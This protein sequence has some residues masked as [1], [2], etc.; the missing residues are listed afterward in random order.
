MRQQDK[1]NGSWRSF[2]GYRN[3]GYL[4]GFLRLNPKT[5][6]TIY[7]QQT[8]NEGLSIPIHLR[9]GEMLPGRFEEGSPIK[10]YTRILGNYNLEANRLEVR[11]VALDFDAPGITE[12]PLESQWMTAMPDGLEPSAFL[13]TLFGKP[14]SITKVVS[15]DRANSVEIAGHV[16]GFMMERERY[17]ENG[18]MMARKL[19]MFVQQGADVMQAIPVR[20]KGRNVQSLREKI[21]IGTPVFVRAQLRMKHIPIPGAQPDERGLVPGYQ[22]MF[23]DGNAWGQIDPKAATRGEHVPD[24]PDWPQWAR[25]LAI[26]G[27]DAVRSAL[28]D[29]AERRKFSADDLASRE[30][31]VGSKHIEEDLDNLDTLLEQS[32]VS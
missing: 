32:G 20:Y 9:K 29:A 30:P 19:Y 28:R 24:L 3:A 4:S 23:I 14:E 17:L 11:A 1:Q 12:M 27:Q 7:L 22:M 26:K 2:R 8:N 5:P 31:E 21:K 10:V 13:P 25:D 16:C 15:Q 18:K 6:R